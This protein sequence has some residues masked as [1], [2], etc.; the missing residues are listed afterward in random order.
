MTTFLSVNAELKLLESNLILVNHYLETK[1]YQHFAKARNS[2][3]DLML[4]LKKS[5]TVVP[6]LQAR[7]EHLLAYYC[8]IRARTVESEKYLRKAEKL[9]ELHKI[10]RASCRERV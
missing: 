7:Y 9:A 1:R 2:A 3:K 4:L 5:T 6:I 10:G 8:R